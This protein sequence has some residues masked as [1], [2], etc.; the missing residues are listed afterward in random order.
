MAKICIDTDAMFMNTN[1]MQKRLEKM[2]EIFGKTNDRMRISRENQIWLGNTSEALYLKYED[3]SSNYEPITESMK[4]I[5]DFINY[6]ANAYIEWDE[7][8]QKL[9]E[10]YDLDINSQK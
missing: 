2:Q 6:I 4:K 1:S 9:A 3:L 5:I 7:N 10:T 8:M